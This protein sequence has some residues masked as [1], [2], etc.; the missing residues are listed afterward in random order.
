MSKMSKFM[1]RLTRQRADSHLPLAG[2][3]YSMALNADNEAEITM[4]GEIVEERPWDYWEE[5]YVD[6]DFIIKGEF[7]DDLDKIIKGGAKKVT[8]RMDS[9]GGDCN[10]SILIHNR[11][12]EL[13]ANGVELSCI[14][15]GVAQSGG[16]L[17]MCAC[18][19]VQVNPSSIIMIH[20][21][22]TYVFGGYNA[23]EL[24]AL[25]KSND[26]YDAAQISIYKRKSGL[27][28]TVISHMMSD[29]TYM[30]GTEAVDKGFADSLMENAEPLNIAAS[31]DRTAF[32]V[33][34]KRIPLAMGMRIPE[35]IFKVAT[36]SDAEPMG[37]DEEE[38]TIN[39]DLP[40]TDTGSEGGSLMATNLTELRTENP[41][42]ASTVE[43]EIRAAVL[44]ESEAANET[45]VSNAVAEERKRLQEIDEISA[46][47]DPDLLAEA[48][49][50]KTACSAQEL[51]FRAMKKQSAAG[52]DF[53]NGLKKDYE[54][55]N[56]E[57]VPAAPAPSGNDNKPKTPEEKKAAAQDDIKSLLGKEAK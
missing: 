18:D 3:C 52:A 2:K 55:S 23:D 56:A 1:A 42:L 57:K 54:A 20:K 45:A 19:N 28:E 17:I 8:I 44:A 31:A 12:R 27:S 38:E 36:D 46:N 14:V 25:A 30:T 15:D 33:R 5:R 48:R 21:C 37:N 32:L 11:L 16:S 51:A 49:Y 4:Y 13:A 53:L 9:I 6:G 29:T 7:L 35:N 50:G 39:N 34:G 43:N 41:A 40:D 10:V 47:V 26:A 24:R 22:W